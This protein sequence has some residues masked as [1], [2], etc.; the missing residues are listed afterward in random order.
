MKELLREQAS[1]FREQP[2]VGSV[3]QHRL[4]NVLVWERLPPS[5]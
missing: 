2:T 1:G 5:F 3:K 4:V